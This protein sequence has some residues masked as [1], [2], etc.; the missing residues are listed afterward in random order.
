MTS[1]RPS[2]LRRPAARW[3][4]ASDSRRARQNGHYSASRHGGVR[5]RH[6][7]TGPAARTEL[8]EERS[9]AAIRPRETPPML[10]LRAHELRVKVL[11]RAPTRRRTLHT[12][13]LTLLHGVNDSVSRIPSPGSSSLE[14][15]S[16]NFSEAETSGSLE[17]S[18]FGIY[19]LRDKL[20]G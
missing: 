2:F 18:K 11:E 14:C 6:D 3:K 15:D 9:E 12:A 4:C 17:Q 19:A 20:P 10:A 5:K 16:D 1:K 8:T 13:V 7:G